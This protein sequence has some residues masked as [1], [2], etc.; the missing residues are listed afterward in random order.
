MK[1]AGKILLALLMLSMMTI[2]FTACGDDDKADSKS[3]EE[4][5]ADYEKLLKDLS[6][7][8]FTGKGA[9]ILTEQEGVK[10]DEQVAENGDFQSTMG[11][12]KFS[13][14]I[15]NVDGK[16]YVKGFYTDKDG[17]KQEFAY[18]APEGSNVADKD[19]SL[20]IDPSQVASF[21]KDENGNA[22]SDISDVKYEKTAGG[23][24]YVSVKITTK[25]DDPETIPATLLFEE[26]SQKLAGLIINTG[27]AEMTV[28]F[29]A[30]NI[31]VD[32]SAYTEGSESDL[33]TAV[34][35]A[36]A[37]ASEGD[38]DDDEE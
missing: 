16:G 1:K 31:K 11:N 20:N 8:E 32:A 36:M 5:Q 19:S 10:L 14:T 22:A 35:S 15:S 12:D 27:K 38:K 17:N 7:V 25:G 37:C 23:K 21:L 4:K 33:M 3:S 24:D 30:F 9:Q 18:L 13:L 2:L 34:L 29:G 28:N 6:K 26:S